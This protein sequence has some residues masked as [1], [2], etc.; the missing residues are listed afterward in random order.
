MIIDVCFTWCQVGCGS[1]IGYLWRCCDWFERT[2]L[3]LLAVMAADTLITACHWFYQHRIAHRQTC[4]FARDTATAMRDGGFDEVIAVAARNSRSPVANVVAAGLSAFGSV[5]PELS[6]SE[7][8]ATAERSFERA[9]KVLAAGQRIGLNKLSSIATCA[10]LIGL[11][12]T[13]FGVAYAFR[14]AAMEKH[15]LIVRTYSDLA[16]AVTFTAMGLL[17]SVLA[18]LCRNSLRNRMQV[19]EGDMLNAKL[20]IIA[21]LTVRSRGQHR[22]E[23]GADDALVGFLSVTPGDSEARS[24]EVPY[25]RQQPLSLAMCLYGLYIALDVISRVVH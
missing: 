10:S 20:D 5:P 8:V 2:T 11:L 19:F 25:D 13:C 24:W 18:I 7:A 14:G 4:A 21:N 1:G 15:T 12:G 23:Q 9:R 16:R 17:L 3:I 22:P 6:D